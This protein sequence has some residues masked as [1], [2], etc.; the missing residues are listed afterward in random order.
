VQGDSSAHARSSAESAI[1]PRRGSKLRVLL[2]EDS[3]VN[4]KLAIRLLEKWGHSV[5]VAENGRRA[6]E[7]W[8]R[9]GCDLILMDVQMA[10]MDGFEAAEEIRRRELGSDG[11]VPIIALTA[12]VMK[13][14]R[15]RCLQVGMDGYLS[16]P[17]H[18]QELLNSI[19]RL[20]PVP[21]SRPA[22]ETAADERTQLLDTDE[23]LR[24]LGGDRELLRELADV[25]FDAYPMQ[26]SELRDAIVRRDR[27][28]MRRT[29]HTLKGELASFGAHGASAAA[30]RL[31]SEPGSSDWPEIEAWL[32]MLEREIEQVR[33][34]LELLREA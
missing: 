3:L 10:E 5:T 18:V 16:K 13:G 29:A 33:P 20:C 6:V 21:Q 27:A 23:T 9:E 11:H 31:E 34:S 14:D 25:M 2:A 7:L 26:L 1:P 28:S 12:H 8:Q 30:W 15:E 32:A 4:Q 22:A 19:E 17:L 24:R